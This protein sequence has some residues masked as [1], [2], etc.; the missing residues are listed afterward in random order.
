M[1]NTREKLF[2]ILNEVKYCGVDI[3]PT[4]LTE[5]A[6]HLIANGVTIET[7]NNKWIPVT[8]RLPEVAITHN[9]R[10]EKSTESVHVICYCK[11]R[12]GKRMVKEGSCKVY[13]D[14]T[15]YWAIPGTID[16][17]THWMPLPEPPKGE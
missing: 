11:Q 6:D 13:S 4:Y 16:S 10:W 14:G 7:D 5:L 15:I 12:S 2:R 3:D 8:E 9:S 17:V 1:P